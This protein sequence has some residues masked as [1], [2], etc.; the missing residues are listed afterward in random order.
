MRVVPMVNGAT[1]F[2]AKMTNTTTPTFCSVI[3]TLKYR[4]QKIEREEK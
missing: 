4:L 1:A 2:A 3:N